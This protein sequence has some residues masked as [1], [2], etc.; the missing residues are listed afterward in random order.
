MSRRVLLI[1]LFISLAVNLFTVGAVV[2]GLAV[3]SRTPPAVRANPNA[4]PGPALWAA[5]GAL[6]PEQ[7][8][9]FRHVLREQGPI[10]N[11]RLRAARQARRDA[12]ALMAREP[13]DA[14]AVNQ[15]LDQARAAE[16][17]A[18]R[19]VE[20]RIVEF[21]GR[22]PPGARA[23]F[24]E[25]LTPSDGEGPQPQRRMLPPGPQGSPTAAP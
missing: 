21:S 2:G 15:A 24:A 25:R 10:T 4:R 11:Q 23:R 19:D 1:A 8:R 14:A 16:M 5:A 18:R 9:E 20:H 17:A 13:F 7:R 6:D 22:L 3:A 12:W